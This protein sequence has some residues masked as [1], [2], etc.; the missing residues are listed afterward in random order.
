[1]LIYV[2]LF[3]Y[4]KQDICKLFKIQRDQLWTVWTQQCSLSKQPCFSPARE[5]CLM[6][7]CLPEKSG[8]V[9]LCWT[10]REDGGSLSIHH[11]IS[12]HEAEAVRVALCCCA[13]VYVDE[14]MYSYPRLSFSIPCR[15]RWCSDHCSVSRTNVRVTVRAILLATNS[16]SCMYTCHHIS[17]SVAQYTTNTHKLSHD[18]LTLSQ[19]L[20][21]TWD[22]V[23]FKV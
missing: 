10:M 22:G 13:S 4:S 11:L 17:T 1:M 7:L 6:A 23:E 2:Y 14:I 8:V 5:L 18:S 20:T 15:P 3:F 9:F 12:G 21:R 19:R 16:Q